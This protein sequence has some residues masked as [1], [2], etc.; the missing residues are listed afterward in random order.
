MKSKILNKYIIGLLA[1]FLSANLSKAQDI[2]VWNDSATVYYKQK[3]YNKSISFYNKIL[4]TGKEN[5]DLYY[6]IGNAY[7]KISDIPMAI[8]YYEKSLKLNPK[9]EDAQ[10][11]LR[12]AKA[13]IVDKIK[14]V[15]EF[16]LKKWFNN[17]IQIFSSNIWA[18]LSIAFFLAALLLILIFLFSHHIGFK[19]ISFW[20]AFVF[21]FISIFS[22]I[23]AKNQKTI[24]FDTQYAIVITPSID[25][26]SSPEEN[27]T[28]LFILHGGTKLQILDNIEEWYKIKIADGNTGWIKSED[29]KAI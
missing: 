21:F 17:I 29:F 19:K 6:N 5:A 16:F 9:D 25:I 3:Q 8:L 2:Q 12:L 14:Q 7:Y 10:Y 20:L 4:A 23:S 18:Y 13:Q 28:T 27:S 1:L 24:N 11:N 22:I 15:P 26:K